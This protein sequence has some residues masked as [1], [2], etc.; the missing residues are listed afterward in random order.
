MDDVE[1][2]FDLHGRFTPGAGRVY[3]RLAPQDRQARIAH[4]G[5][6]LGI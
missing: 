3:F 1:R 6:K 4:I 5:L 2:T